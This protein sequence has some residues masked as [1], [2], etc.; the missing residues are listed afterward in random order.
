MMKATHAIA[1]LAASGL[2]DAAA[3]E[4]LEIDGTVVSNCAAHLAPAHS[5]AF[6]RFRE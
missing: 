1:L 3:F 6:P 2:S 4:A 5:S